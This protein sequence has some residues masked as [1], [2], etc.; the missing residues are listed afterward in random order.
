[1]S[2]IGERTLWIKNARLAFPHLLQP[3]PSTNPQLPPKYNG[4]FIMEPD[5]PEWAEIAQVVNAIALE[6]WTVNANGVMGMINADKRM[7]C[8]GFGADKVNQTTGLI[9]DGF[10]DK[11]WISGSNADRPDLRGQD[12]QPC[13]PTA[14]LAAMFAGGNMV[15]AVISLW[16][17]DNEHGKAIRGQLDGVMYIAEGEKFGAVGPDVGTIFQPVAGA[18][19]P[20]AVMPGMAAPAPAPLAAGPTINDFL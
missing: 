4:V 8:F 10:Q 5:A 13:P 9:Y 17:Q 6:T 2:I 14:P 15:Q 19:A 16:P 11:L 12:A 7:R 3:Q 18:P 1:M 20:T